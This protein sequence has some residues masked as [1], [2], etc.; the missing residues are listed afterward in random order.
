MKWLPLLWAALRR[1]A[2]RSVL[3]L[4]SIVVAFLLVGT[5][6]GLNASFARLV[7]EARADRVVVTA[8]FGQ[9][10]PN[11]HANQIRQFDGVTAISSLS[12][13]EA[14]YQDQINSFLI[15]MTDPAMTE[16]NSEY[17]VTPE[18]FA[19]VD[20]VR[21]GLIVSQSVA[22]RFSWSVGDRIPLEFEQ[23]N[24]DGLRDWSFQIVRIVPDISLV[25]EGFTIG[26]F[27]YFDEERG[28]RFND[29]QQISFLIEDAEQAGAMADAVE[30][31]F[32]N[33]QT[34]VTVMPDRIRTETQLQ[35]VFDMQFFTYAITAAALF[36]L[37]F[38]TCNVMAQAVRERVPEFAV[39]KTIGFTDWGIFAL[40]VA[41]AS[42]LCLAGAGFGLLLAGLLPNLVNIG[43]LSVVMPS[44]PP[45]IITPMVAG[46]AIS[47]A[48]VIAIVSG[49]P[50]AWRIKRLSI[51]AALGGI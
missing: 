23:V 34:P 47:A 9:W 19:E 6:T 7:S 45:P 4:L 5:T 32:T 33:S 50:S 2:G 22:Q 31:Y 41:E 30:E 29:V 26:N 35:A 10:I 21:D 17:N 16:V 8:R 1:K 28:R 24:K 39:M 43:L 36:M 48:L 44:I 27:L 20:R 40:I 42:I 15:N 18:I 46:F 13:I 51:A 14:S 12:M 49:V 3:T 37:A 25:P 11:T 38:L